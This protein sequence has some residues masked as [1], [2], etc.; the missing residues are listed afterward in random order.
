MPVPDQSEL[1]RHSNSTGVLFN[2]RY[3]ADPFSQIGVG[4]VLGVESLGY[5][6]TFLHIE[7]SLKELFPQ[8]LQQFSAPRVNR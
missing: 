1:L 2:D 3:L 8:P 5:L 4:H 7:V 6:E